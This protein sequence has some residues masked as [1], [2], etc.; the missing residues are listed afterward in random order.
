MNLIEILKT[1]EAWL[2]LATI[3]QINEFILI[4][5]KFLPFYSEIYNTR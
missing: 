5:L 4:R 3:N 2:N 1:A